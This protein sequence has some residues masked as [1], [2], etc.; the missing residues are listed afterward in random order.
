MPLSILFKSIP[1]LVPGKRWHAFEKK[2]RQYGVNLIT[3]QVKLKGEG[4]VLIKPYEDVC[5]QFSKI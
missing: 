5:F 3:F 1:A 2:E 4:F